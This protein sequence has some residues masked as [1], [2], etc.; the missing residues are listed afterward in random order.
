M[1]SACKKGQ[2]SSGRCSETEKNAQKSVTHWTLCS[3]KMETLLQTGVQTLPRAPQHNT[4]SSSG[5]RAHR[6]TQGSPGSLAN[7]FP[8]IWAALASPSFAIFFSVSVTAKTQVQ[9]KCCPEHLSE[10]VFCI[11]TFRFGPFWVSLGH[12]FSAGP[13]QG[14]LGEQKRL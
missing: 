5:W 12:P 11:W 13:T 6:D 2:T 1:L 7:P 8:A 4:D 3:A 10:W 9:S 14:T